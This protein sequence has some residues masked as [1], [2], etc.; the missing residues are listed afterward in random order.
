MIALREKNPNGEMLYLILDQ[1][2]SNK[3]LSVRA[4][5]RFLNIKVVFLPPYSPNLNPIE[6][7]WKFFKK[8]VLYGKYYEKLKDFEF[9]CD[10]FFKNIKTYK[11]DLKTLITDNFS[12]VGT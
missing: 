4:L 10:S 8:K 7:L 6:R 11:S 5:A 12:T 1:G 3:A 9:A 2:P